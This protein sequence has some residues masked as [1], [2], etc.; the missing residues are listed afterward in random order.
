MMKKLALITL[1]LASL[2]LA[3]CSMMGIDNRSLEYKK[4]KTLKPLEVPYG[5]QMREETALY[6]APV[7]EQRALNNAPR[8]E[9]RRGN[10][11]E[12]PRPAL[13]ASTPMNTVQLQ[14]LR[15]H[16]IYDANKNPLLQIA[17]NTEEIWRY[18]V[19]TASSLNYKL[20]S[21]DK[22]SVVL[23]KDGKQYLLYL[24][25]IGATHVLALY[26]EAGSFAS[27]EIATEIL[28]QIYQNWPV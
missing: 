6:P 3:G 16:M 2:S 25:Q 24:S 22:T 11:Y 4:A 17:G 13:G 26:D 9:N 28:T 20:T 5:M 23:E 21:E 1:S 15:P 18:V 19:A 10:R 14:N 27:Q 8:Y 12:L 7:I